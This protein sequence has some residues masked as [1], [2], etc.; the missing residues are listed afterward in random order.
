MRKFAPPV[1]RFYPE[2]WSSDRRLVIFVCQES[3]RSQGRWSFCVTRP[4]LEV[5]CYG[6][7]PEEAFERCRSAIY[8]AATLYMLRGRPPARAHV[9]SAQDIRD[10]G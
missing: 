1:H 6:A 9:L 3:T 8:R 7:E 2:M 5:L 10:A 4:T